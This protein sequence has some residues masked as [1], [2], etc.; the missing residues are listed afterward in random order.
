MIGVS[1]VGTE[2]GVVEFFMEIESRRKEKWKA[3]ELGIRGRK[4]LGEGGPRELKR[5]QFFTNYDCRLKNSKRGGLAA[6]I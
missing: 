2:D 5:L 6:G 3:E 4:K 1:F